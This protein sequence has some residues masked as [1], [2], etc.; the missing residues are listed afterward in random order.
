MTRYRLIFIIL[1]GIPV[2]LI[3]T[4]LLAVPSSLI[5]TQIEKA[6]K[7]SGEKSMSLSVTGLKKGIFFTLSA[8]SLDLLMDNKPAMQVSVFSGTF[9]PR[10]LLGGQLAFNIEGNIGTGD[11][12]GT[13]KLPIDGNISI[14]NAE[15]NAISYFARFGIDINGNLSSEINIKNDYV[16]VVFNIPDLSIGDSESSV[17]PLLNTFRTMQGAL[18]I[19]GNNINIESVSLEGEKGYAR[20]KGDITNGVMNLKLE[21]MPLTGKLNTLESMFIGKYIVSPGYYVIPIKRPLL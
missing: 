10:H 20:L 2:F 16:H 8:D 11:V 19:R 1:I 15:L 21:L 17:I 7:Q 12:S 5:E 13:V 3:L 9:S 14:K 18:S 6:L 4:W